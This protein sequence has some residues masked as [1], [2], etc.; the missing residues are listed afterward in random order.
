L[1]KFLEL[2]EFPE[3]ELLNIREMID[4]NEGETSVEFRR[5]EQVL[6]I[7]NNLSF[8][9]SNASYMSHQCPTLLEFLI[10]CLHVK[11]LSNLTDLR[12]HSLDTLANI[13]RK[14][15]LKRLNETHR[16]LLLNSLQYL[17]VG[18]R[19]EFNNFQ[20]SQNIKPQDDQNN[21]TT[22]SNQ[23]SHT[24]F[25]SQ[26]KFDIM[27]GLEILTKLC[28]QLIDPLD[29]ESSNEKLIA[30]YTLKNSEE[31]FIEKIVYR[32]EEL[33]ST[34]DVLI[35]LHSLECLYNLSQFSQTICNLIANYP[36]EDRFSRMIPILVNFLTLDMSNFGVQTTPQPTTAQ[37]VSATPVII[38]Q[39]QQQQ[40]QQQILVANNPQQ[41]AVPVF[42]P[43]QQVAQQPIKMF[44]IIQPNGQ[45]AI[46]AAAAPSSTNQ[47][48][49]QVVTSITSNLNKATA[50]VQQSLNPGNNL[51][52]IL[53]HTVSNTNN[54]VIKMSN[55]AVSNSSSGNDLSGADAKNA[56]CNWLVS[57]FQSDSNAEI[58]KTQ[59]YPYYQQVAKNNKW[60]VLTIPTFFEILK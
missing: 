58:S 35:L 37:N 49:Q 4:E 14:L 53:S 25:G 2:N 42:L 28:S 10:L 19:E 34:Q 7:L 38:Q 43:G 51:T 23:M 17:I 57:C 18:N 6:I 26:D 9:D 39:Q 15:E 47:I 32:L 33:L 59:L 5:I 31:L 20:N 11:I 12:K 50:L 27:R 44:K 24:L 1:I 54:A 60:N 16:I 52:K 36:Q 56:L 30:K 46:I 3:Q 55:E 40:Q 21:S 48:P 29:E 22:T 41:T 8:D 13:S 45:Q